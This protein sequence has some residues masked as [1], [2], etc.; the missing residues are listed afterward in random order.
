MIPHNVSVD[1]LV[2]YYNT[3][4]NRKHIIDV[5]YETCLSNDNEIY[6]LKKDIENLEKEKENLENKIQEILAYVHDAMIDGTTESDKDLILKYI[7]NTIGG[8][9]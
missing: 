2:Y 7:L 6:W 8:E 1:E 9:K 4:G 3:P 5:L